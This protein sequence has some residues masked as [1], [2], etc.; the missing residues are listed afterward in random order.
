MSRVLRIAVIWLL[1]L[2]MPFQGVAAA[3]MMLCGPV[4]E[5]A[6]AHEHASHHAQQHDHAASSH[7]GGEAD[8]TKCSVCAS[9][10]TSATLPSPLATYDPPKGHAV[11]QTAPASTTAS[12]L[13]GGLDRPPRSPL[14]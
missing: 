6:A 10:C 2:A 1:A 11:F 4:H 8:T 5:D 14:A 12:F 13:T 7:D 9:C 3:T